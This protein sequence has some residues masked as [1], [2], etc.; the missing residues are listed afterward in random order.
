MGPNV[1]DETTNI[2]TNKPIK[3]SS[4]IQ[5]EPKTHNTDTQTELSIET[6]ET[7]EYCVSHVDLNTTTQEETHPNVKLPTMT[8]I[9]STL[10]TLKKETNTEIEDDSI[11]YRRNI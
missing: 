7:Y 11:L 4:Y 10:A 9:H 8:A 3:T 6:K 1:D 2:Q 5:T